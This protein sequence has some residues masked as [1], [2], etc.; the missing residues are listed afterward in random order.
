MNE[1]T[2]PDGTILFGGHH[3][4]QKYFAKAHPNVRIVSGESARFSAGMIS[5]CTPLVL[6]NPAHIIHSEFWKIRKLVR[7]H[8]TRMEFVTRIQ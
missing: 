2:Y 3:R 5:P 4:W 1:C 7:R 6:V 8:G